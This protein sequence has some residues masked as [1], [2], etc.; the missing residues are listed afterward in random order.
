MISGTLADVR[1]RDLPPFAAAIASGAAAVMPGHLVVPELTGALPATMSPA[2]IAMLRGDLGFTGVVV[3]DGLEMQA[4][5]GRFGIPMTSVRALAAG[6]DLLCFG[7]HTDHDVYLAV[8]AAIVDAVKSGEL[9][10]PRLQEAA[11][12]VRSL[13]SR[14]GTPGQPLD[15]AAT[16]PGTVPIWVGPNGV[17]L[18]AARRAIRVA[19]P[20]PALTDP[21]II[22]IEPRENAAAGQFGWGLAPWASPSSV[23]RLDP[24]GALDAKAILADAAGRSLVVAVRDAHVDPRTRDLL[25]TLLA[26]RPDTVLIEMGLPYWSPPPGTSYLATFGAS[27]ASAQAAAELLGLAD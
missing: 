20:L 22:E 8:C 27:R 10:L 18:T 13:R 2:A 14:L 26:A 12:R 5:S 16:V 19:G 21:L 25:T 23:R 11:D 24:A 3:T 15:P 9:P 4:V 6:V 17:G 1:R 7:Q